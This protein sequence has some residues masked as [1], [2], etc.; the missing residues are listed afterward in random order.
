MFNNIYYIKHVIFKNIVIMKKSLSNI[1]QNVY[2][3][4]CFCW[5][6]YWRHDG[7]L[8]TFKGLLEDLAKLHQLILRVIVVVWRSGQV[9]Q[10]ILSLKSS[11]CFKKKY[12]GLQTFL[13]IFHSQLLLKYFIPALSCTRMPILNKKI[14][15]NQFFIVDQVKKLIEIAHMSGYNRITE[16][17]TMSTNSF[18]ICSLIDYLNFFYE[19]HVMY[20]M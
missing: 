11:F 12:N 10:S 2:K 8:F 6:Y 4:S 1:G 5:W 17:S 20:V 9:N 7:S 3:L 16:I 19:F 18:L 13:R 14:Q 15:I